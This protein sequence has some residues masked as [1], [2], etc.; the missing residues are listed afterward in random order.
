[1]KIRKSVSQKNLPRRSPLL[2]TLVFWM[3]LDKLAAPVY[4]WG[5]VSVLIVWWWIWFLPDVILRED[6]LLFKDDE[7]K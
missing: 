2:G 6:V 3:V 5:F 4:V 7:T 1:M